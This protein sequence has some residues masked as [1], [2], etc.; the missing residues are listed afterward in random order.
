MLTVTRQSEEA[1]TRQNSTELVA[2]FFE[3]Q[4]A[5]YLHFVLKA[6]AWS[7]HAG[8]SEQSVLEARL[9]PDMFSF[10]QQ[11]EIACQLAM[12]TFSRL[13]GEDPPSPPQ[14]RIVSLDDARRAIEHAIRFLPNLAARVPYG[15]EAASVTLE[16]PTG[17]KLHFTG[18]RFVDEFCIPN[19]M[20]HMTTTY[21][22]LRNQGAPL[23]KLDFHGVADA[24]HREYV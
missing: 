7:R 6:S 2:N 10:S 12:A 5:N 23:G 1:K 22:I 16:V 19:F 4:L 21:A 18:R 3:R 20:F 8:F 15:W 17:G 14:P 13:A 9:A 11:V 24:E